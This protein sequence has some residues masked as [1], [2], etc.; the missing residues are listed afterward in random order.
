MLRVVWNPHGFHLASILTKGQKRRRQC[1]SGHVLP[2]IGA[3]RDV[4][5][6][7]S[8]MVQAGNTKRNVA[9]RIK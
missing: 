8:L 1:Y 7:R 3:L 6:R 9:K 2:D 4:R 5:D